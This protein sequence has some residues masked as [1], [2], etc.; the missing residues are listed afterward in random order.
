MSPDPKAM[1]KTTAKPYSKPI[2]VI[3]VTS[4]K[5]GV[6][7]TNVVANLAVALAQEGRRVLVWD[8]DLGLA[9]LDVLL[10]L[11]PEFNIHHLLQGEKTLNEILIE[12]PAGIMVMPASS[13]VQE[14]SNLGEGQKTLLLSELDA[15]ER[16]F[17]FLLIDTGAGISSNVMYFNLAAQERIVVVSPE[18]TSI[19][20]AY[21]L[22]KVM[23]SKYNEKKFKVLPN[24]VSGVREA[25][26]VYSLLAAVADKHLAT[27]A[28]SM[29]YLGFI[30]RDEMLV[31][32]VKQQKAVLEAFPGSGASKGFRD[33]AK[34]ILCA[35]PDTSLDGN[36]KFFWRRLLKV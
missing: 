30:P 15:F 20:D 17:D 31:K 29:D 1:A 25:K 11:K 18:P 34:M 5:G 7:K 19:T 6:G 21:A 23:A 16:K 12:G 22:I 28:I 2:R 8:A 26:A 13:G 32:A 27:L 36:I 14:L 4:G 3:S 24:M 35:P 33:L 10:G 9:N